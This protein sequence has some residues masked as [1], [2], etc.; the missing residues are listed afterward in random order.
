[1]SFLMDACHASAS[2]TD[3]NEA[4][5]EAVTQQHVSTGYIDM[6]IYDKGKKI[7]FIC[8]HKIDSILSENQIKKYVDSSQEL[9]PDYHFYSVLLTKMRGQHTEPA[10]VRT[11][12]SKITQLAKD[13]LDDESLMLTESDQFVL[14][15]FVDFMN[16]EGLGVPDP[17]NCSNLLTYYSTLEVSKGIEKIFRGLANPVMQWHQIIPGIEVFPAPR[18]DFRPCFE[19]KW[20][21]MG[22][23][24]FNNW[25]PGLFA[26]VILDGT[27]HKLEPVDRSKGPDL[28]VLLDANLSNTEEYYQIYNSEW[29][30]EIMRRLKSLSNREGFIETSSHKWKLVDAP[31]NRWRIVILQTPLL[32]VIKY[33]SSLDDQRE[34]IMDCLSDGINLFLTQSGN[35]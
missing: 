4:E 24:F 22:I 34:K 15:Q 30:Q 7:A 25:R 3:D 1:M 18:D 10:D 16:M 5:I 8:E 35:T 19:N 14:E 26:G 23:S 12:W 9:E 27:D 20:G 13:T 6:V 33:C 21:R 11:V 31:K 17:I 29:F 28:V 32:D 2:D